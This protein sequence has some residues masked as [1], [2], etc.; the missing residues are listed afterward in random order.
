MTRLSIVSLRS[1]NS[2]WFDPSTNTP[3]GTPPPSVS[4]LRLVPCLPRS[5][6]FLPTFSPP[7]RGF[8]HRPVHRE[9]RPI[10]PVERLVFGQS[11]LP[12][13]QKHAGFAPLLE[14][15]VR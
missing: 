15:S 14:A 5:V 4:R 2:L 10:N 11:Y 13:L 6:G 7:E 8:S 1:L 3:I 9:P 12:E